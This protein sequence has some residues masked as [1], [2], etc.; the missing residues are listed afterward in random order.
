MTEEIQPQTWYSVVLGLACT[1]ACPL[2]CMLFDWVL[3]FFNIETPIAKRKRKL[4]E[5]R[6]GAVIKKVLEEV[7][8]AERARVLAPHRKNQQEIATREATLAAA[9]VELDLEQNKFAKAR[10]LLKI[11]LPPRQW[12]EDAESS[13]GLR[14]GSGG[15]VGSAMR[16]RR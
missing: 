1:I 2:V 16:R 7:N 8:G 14:E 5:E 3:L 11:G 4:E 10:I 6:L 9:Q 15:S 12:Q 13:L